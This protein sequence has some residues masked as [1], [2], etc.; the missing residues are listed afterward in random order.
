MN[1]EFEIRFTNIDRT[2]ITEKIKELSW[3]C[4]KERTLM[5]RITFDNP[6]DPVNSYVRVRDE[7]DQVTCTYKNISKKLDIYAVKELETTVGDLDTMVKILQN[8]GVKMKSYQ[9]TYRKTWSIDEE[10]DLMLDEWPGLNPFIEIEWDN[11][12]VVRK[13]VEILGFDY[14]D[15]LFGAVDVV[16]TKELWIWAEVINNLEEITFENPPIGN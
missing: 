15:W 5:K 1:T 12:E 14:E 11:E 8:V 16:Y 10:I 4:T 6:L 2:K 9:E 7:W 3:I 13:Y